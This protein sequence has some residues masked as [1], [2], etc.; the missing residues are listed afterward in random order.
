MTTVPSIGSWLSSV[1]MASTAAASAESLSPRPIH[2][3]AAIAAAS[4]TRTISRTS[5]RSRTDE[6][7]GPSRF[8]DQSLLQVSPQPIGTL[9]SLVEAGSVLDL[10]FE[11]L[12]ADSN[13]ARPDP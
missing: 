1:R 8:I 10:M 6:A 9:A 5:T 2:L 4:V 12:G 11:Q 7:A 3:E 13:G